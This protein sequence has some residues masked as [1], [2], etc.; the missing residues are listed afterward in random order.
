M[1]IRSTGSCCNNGLRAQTIVSP[2]RRP[3]S[4]LS[5]IHHGLL[6]I[7]LLCDYTHSDRR[8][9]SLPHE[10]LRLDA[11]RSACKLTQRFVAKTVFLT[12]QLVDDVL[13]YCW[14]F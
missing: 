7:R 4:E 10:F 11:F 6:P 3:I 12:H 13:V 14:S 5:A 9:L 8:I 1:K 2:N